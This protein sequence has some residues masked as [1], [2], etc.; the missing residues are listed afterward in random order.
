MYLRPP[1]LLPRLGGHV[2]GILNLVIRCRPRHSIE[3]WTRRVDYTVEKAR[4][5]VDY[6]RIESA[7]N[8]ASRMHSLLAS[9]HHSDKM[10]ITSDL[11]AR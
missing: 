4:A 5:E 2:D 8:I 3:L 1:K 9:W 11:P 10:D 6:A 7:V